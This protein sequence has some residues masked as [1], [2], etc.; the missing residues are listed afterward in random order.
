MNPHTARKPDADDAVRF[1]PW[2]LAP[3]PLT[4]V[5]DDA[6]LAERLDRLGREAGATRFLSL[7]RAAARD[8]GLPGGFSYDSGHG[9]IVVDAAGLDAAARAALA[10]ASLSRPCIW[11]IETPDDAP[12]DA[13]GA[14][15]LMPRDGCS[16]RDLVVAALGARRALAQADHAG[17]RCA[18]RDARAARS[19]DARRA[20]VEEISPLAHGLA[21][22]VDILARDETRNPDS[23]ANRVALLRDWTGALT[24]SIAGAQQALARE[25][26]ASVD[27]RRAVARALAGVETEPFAEGKTLVVCDSC[28]T[29]PVACDEDALCAAARDLVASVLE[30]EAASRRVDVL[31]WRARDDIR[32]AIVTGSPALRDGEE[33]RAAP[34]LHVA[35]AS[36]GAFQQAIADFERLGARVEVRTHSASGAT[37]AIGLPAAG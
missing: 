27:L 4:L 26:G 6:A 3:G 37:V 24:R 8:G 18:E 13:D 17:A 28:D 33:A 9:T 2:R 23:F 20:L 11:L 25:A 5:S 19:D 36:D 12:D 35:R 10:R 32:L 21:G 7:S 30:R 1:E 16:A 22:L 14:I 31:V 15:C 34:A 29:L